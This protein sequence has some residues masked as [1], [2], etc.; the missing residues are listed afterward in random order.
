V[1]KVDV[2]SRNCEF[3]ILFPSDTDW[4]INLWLSWWCWWCWLV[5]IEKCLLYDLIYSYWELPA[6]QVV[7]MCFMSNFVC[8]LFPSWIKN[9]VYPNWIH[10]LYFQICLFF[11]NKPFERILPFLSIWCIDRLLLWSSDQ[12]SWLQIQRSRF[13]SR[14]YHVA[15]EVVGQDWGPFSLV[16]KI[17]EL[18]E[19]KSSSSGLD[20]WEYSR[21][22]LLRW[23]CGTLD[24]QKL[25]L[26]SP[27]NSGCSVGIVH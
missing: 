7:L 3:Y 13:D 22:D 20:H 15:R 25:A 2:A 1:W 17:E 10:F 4:E 14:H 5:E 18:L 23:S 21:R 24:P 9:S 19:R 16:S 27:T 6:T 11:I 26:T 12:S 8:F